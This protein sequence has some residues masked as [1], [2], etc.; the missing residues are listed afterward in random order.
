MDYVVSKKK[1]PHGL[2]IVVTDSNILG[3]IFEEN[4]L[5]LDLSKEFYQGEK[6]TKDEV[7]KI[8][9]I[10]RDLHLTGKKSVALGV[11][12]DLVDSTKILF[13]QKV[14]HAEVV[15]G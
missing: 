15:I 12:M 3:K 11:E 6:T 13:V 10:S 14:P 9:L 4:K 8:M 7:K 1:G 2:L 5:Q